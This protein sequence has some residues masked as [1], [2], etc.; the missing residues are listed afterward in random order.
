MIKDY[1]KLPWTEIKK[2]KGRSWLT[3]I[4]VFIGITAIIALITLGQG[5]EN[6][7]EKQFSALGQDKLIITA[8]GSTLTM[9]L[10]T[11]AVKI[12]DND[13][14]LIQK[15][16]GVKIATGM[17]YTTGKIEYN[18]QTRYF[19]ISGMPVNPDENELI[20]QVQNY[21]LLEGR[22]LK[23]GDKYQTVLGYEYTKDALFNK[24]VELGNKITVHD[25]EFKVVGFFDKTGSPP[26]DRS[27][28]IPLDT[29]GEV[30]NKKEEL[31]MIIAQIQPGENPEKM[32]ERIKQELR[33]ERNLKEG[34]ED[35]SIQTPEQLM[36]TFSTIL[37][38]IQIVLVGIA[39]ISLLV[40]GVGITNTM[41]T[42]VL[43]RTKEIGILKALGAK[44]SQILSLFLIESGLYGLGGG[45]IG[46]VLGISL[47]KLTEFIFAQ[48]VGE[49]FLA[50]EY[51]WMLIL[52]TL[53]F[54]FLIG[55]LSGIAPARKASKL[56]PIDAL[57]YE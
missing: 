35:F 50:I 42:A 44:N 9:G 37:N 19:F 52:G 10:S 41:Y 18:H 36:S 22:R 8:K 28:L 55:C 4:G 3:L 14:E 38:I 39:G 27:V 51:N 17:I 54:S 34:E 12:T 31:G 5:L 56:N 43:E 57:R 47:A 16:S 2:K 1:F 29:Y 26:D 48:V 32:A 49:A 21:K 11:D 23:A 6:A 45:L 15:V 46:V 25:Q 24:K 33:K 40:G 13:L 7:I 20:S 30:F 53:I